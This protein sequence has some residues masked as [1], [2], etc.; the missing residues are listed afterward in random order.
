MDQGI[1]E[2]GT[3]LEADHRQKQHDPDLPQ[4]QV[5][6]GRHEPVELADAADPRQD[7]RHHQR[8]ARQAE[9][10][11]GREARQIEGDGAK[12]HAKTDPDKDRQHLHLLQLLLHVADHISHR[13]DGIEASHQVEDV[14]KLQAGLA[15]RH[16][17]DTGPIEARDHHVITLFDVEIADLLAQHLLVGHYHPL[18]AQVGTTG[19]ERGLHLLPQHQQHLVQRVAF[20]HQV[21]QV[22][23]LDARIGP[24][25]HQLI[26]AL[27]P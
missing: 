12:Q 15:G 4:R 23:Q 13:F 26:A 10:E 14:T 5:G 27:E 3:R 19:R 1:D 8:S 20:T 18:D 7:Q 16:Q 11:R 9:L 2:A 21:E 22:A 17:L 25:H 6:T 24:R